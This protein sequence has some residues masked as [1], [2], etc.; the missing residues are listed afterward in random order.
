MPFRTAF[1]LLVLLACSPAVEPNNTDTTPADSEAENDADVATDA[2]EGVTPEVTDLGLADLDTMLE[3]KD[4]ELIN[5]HIPYAGEIVGTDV[6]I[7]YNTVD[8]IETYL[9][10]DHAAKAVL[11]CLTGPMS[12][13]A[14]AELVKR[15]Y[16]QI[17]D[18]PDGL[19]QWEAAG[20]PTTD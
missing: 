11:Y 9:G 17:Y 20:Y 3:N 2:C 19:Y 13:A 4:F 12:A 5:V 18:L 6:N 7:P 10:G 16:C 14:T 8:D 15:G 1:P